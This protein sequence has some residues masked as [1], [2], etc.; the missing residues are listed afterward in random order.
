MTNPCVLPVVFP[1]RAASPSGMSAELNA[2]GSV[3]RL[4]CGDIML[5]VFLGNEA[6]GGPTNIYLRRLGNAVEALPLLGPASPA[7]YQTD[8]RGMS[9]TGSWGDL[10]FRVRLVLAASAKAWFWHVELENTGNTAVT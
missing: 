3:R 8:E 5:N 1:F 7:S 6:D 2:N 10:T 4:D 9:A